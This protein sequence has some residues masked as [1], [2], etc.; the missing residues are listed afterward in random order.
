[1]LIAHKRKNYTYKHTKKIPSTKSGCHFA[2]SGIH[3]NFFENEK[4]G[5][6]NEKADSLPSGR[7]NLNLTIS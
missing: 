7:I 3:F 1:M 4:E 6:S 2:S 5:D